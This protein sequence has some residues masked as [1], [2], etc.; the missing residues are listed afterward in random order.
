MILFKPFK[1]LKRGLMK[2][3]DA[4]PTYFKA[5][6]RFGTL[7]AWQRKKAQREYGDLI[8]KNQNRRVLV[9][10]HL[11]YPESWKEIREYLLN[12][13][14]YQWDLMVTYPIERESQYDFE[15]IREVN[16]RVTLLPCPNVGYDVAP[17]L[18]ALKQTD[19]DSYD[20]VFKLQSKG[21]KRRFIY[22]YRQ[23]FMGRG[24]FLNLYEGCVGAGAVHK[25]IDVIANDPHT[26]LACAE[27]L[28]V[29]DPLYK[30]NIIK[31][32]LEYF[33]LQGTDNY[34]FIAGTCFAAKP[35]V[36]KVFQEMSYTE[37][38]FLQGG[39]KEGR[40]SLAHALER[41]FTVWNEKLGYGIY[42]NKVLRIR[43][44]LKSPFEYLCSKFSSV[45]LLD[46]PYRYDDAYF[47]RD[48]DNKFVLY[49]KKRIKL[50][51]LKYFH[52]DLKKFIP[53]KETMPFRFLRGDMDAYEEY[54]RYQMRNRYPVVSIDKFLNLKK[55]IE[56]NG[57]Q[58][59]NIILT[60]VKNIIADGQ[61]RACVLATIYGL[62]HEVDA[63][64]IIK[65]NRQSIKR[66]L[67]QIKNTAKGGATQ[68]V[69]SVVIPIHNGGRYLLRCLSSVALAVRRIPAEVLLI[70]D[71]ST[72]R[73]A[74]RAKKYIRRHRGFRFYKNE[75]YKGAGYTVNYGAEMARGKYVAFVNTNAIITPDFFQNMLYLMEQRN[76]PLAVSNACRIED[77]TVPIQYSEESAHMQMQY[78]PD[79]NE[80]TGFL[81]GMPACNKLYQAACLRESKIQFPAETDYADIDIQFACQLP[82]PEEQVSAMRQYG[83][84]WRPRLPEPCVGEGQEELTEG[85]QQ[86]EGQEELT[87]DGTQQDADQ[88][89]VSEANDENND[90]DNEADN[91]AEET[92]SITGI[93]VEPVR[94]FI[95]RAV[96]KSEHE[97]VLQVYIFKGEQ[98]LLLAGYHVN[99]CLYNDF[100]GTEMPLLVRT[101]D[102]GVNPAADIDLY[103]EIKLTGP[104]VEITIDLTAVNGEA[105]AGNNLIMLDLK[106]Q[107]ENLRKVLRG[108]GREVAVALK[109]GY[110]VKASGE[111]SFIGCDESGTPAVNY[112]RPGQNAP[113]SYLAV[114]D[115]RESVAAL[116]KLAL[117]NGKRDALFD[118]LLKRV[119]GNPVVDAAN[120]LKPRERKYLNLFCKHPEL[121]LKLYSL[122]HR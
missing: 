121:Y 50:G 19:L 32:T 92:G 73:S 99:A 56:E 28:I 60:R 70:E 13:Q 53:L 117:E 11:F 103:P 15:S 49:R 107:G 71:G 97:T 9:I 23:M 120:H 25:T 116:K 42:G 3:W 59:D 91:E 76:S 55:S 36:L 40:L 24:W 69:L 110:C 86:E 67:S 105:F 62:D 75:F 84:L 77:S 111:R 47:L 38:D 74:S 64:Q 90:E 106:S 27:N 68:P 12:L 61:H 108:A 80:Y 87:G 14:G 113:I 81:L 46:L 104:S 82:V 58:E 39:V 7:R 48:L 26:G 37:Q 100:T 63:L 119:R 22:I 102:A 5:Y 6:H 33:G 21:V 57:F 66:T 1:I 29:H 45:R 65:L 44:M 114:Q 41:Y 95:V 89:A 101:E 88:E 85:T 16:A 2:I 122:K 98:N 115:L 78:A 118:E 18:A 96:S 52:A 4:T 109:K 83:C 30:E 31:K 34:Y 51:D 8:I 35:Q 94:S 79:K 43:R 17:F 20:V 10:L 112:F 72:D 93:V 54:R